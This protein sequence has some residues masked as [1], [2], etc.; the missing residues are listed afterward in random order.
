MRTL[1]VITTAAAAIAATLFFAQA[2]DAD[3]IC[4]QRCEDRLCADSCVQTHVRCENLDFRNGRGDRF[5]RDRY[6]SMELRVPGVGVE[7]NR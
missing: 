5:E 2:A 3:R 7:A 4:K 1:R 6:P